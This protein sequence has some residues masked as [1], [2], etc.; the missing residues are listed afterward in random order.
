VTV[1]RVWR[2]GRR[3]WELKQ[4]GGSFA[5]TVR[6]GVAVFEGRGLTRLRTRRGWF[7]YSLHIAGFELV[8]GAFVLAG[9]EAPLLLLSAGG[10]HSALPREELFMPIAMTESF[11]ASAESAAVKATL[12]RSSIGRYLVSSA[13]AGAF[14][15][16]A[17]VLLLMT[18][19]A[20]VKAQSPGT[21]LMQGSVFGVALTLVV[22]AGAELFTGCVMTM[23]HGLADRK[24]SVTDLGLVWLASWL[25]NLAGSLAFAALVNGSG[26][27]SAG[28]PK[29]ETTVYL[30]TLAGII[31]TKVGLTVGQ[32]FLRGVL[33]NFLVCL[34]LW[35]AQRTASDAAKAIVLFWVLLAFVASGFEHSVANMTVFS[36][37]IFAHVPGATAATMF[38]NLIWV[39][40]GNIVGGGALVGIT[41]AYLGRTEVPR[42]PRRVRAYA[43]RLS[44]MLAESPAG[45]APSPTSL[46]RVQVPAYPEEV[47]PVYDAE[48]DYDTVDTDLGE[49][50]TGFTA[51]LNGEK[52]K[53]AA[54]RRT[55]TT[56][57]PPRS[58]GVATGTPA[59]RGTSAGSRRRSTK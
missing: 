15:G 49:G 38:H 5:L 10:A 46:T 12:A 30:A 44:S 19:S 24:S 17:V 32:V 29:G 51:V 55:R 34:G 23:L 31:Q 2:G 56:T 25:G 50:L 21:K 18:S 52:P 48:T 47:A 7:S 40:L 59:Q 42:R 58:R 3:R 11:Q 14:V 22:F 39:S 26:I 36:L 6:Q 27:L 57:P 16:I 4:A 53:P 13:L 54:P 8:V 45:V 1:S 35:M 9:C 41:Y 28:A 43:A 20:F 33:C 37:A